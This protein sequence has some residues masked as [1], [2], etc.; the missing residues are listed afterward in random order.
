MCNFGGLV[1]VDETRTLDDLMIVRRVAREDIERQD[2]TVFGLPGDGIFAIF[3][4]AIG[5]VRAALA[6][7]SRLAALPKLGALRFR[8][9]LHVGEVLFEG[10]MPFG[11][12]IVIAARLESLADPGGIL[13]SGSVMEATASRV[14]A[15]FAENGV[16]SLKH[17][18][19][20]IATY[21][22]LPPPLGLPTSAG[23][24]DALDATAFTRPFDRRA[25]AAAWQE[26]GLESAAGMTGLR[27]PRAM[28]FVL[29]ATRSIEAAPTLQA[30]A[31]PESISPVPLLPLPMLP[32]PA[33]PL[34]MLPAPVRPISPSEAAGSPLRRPSAPPPVV[35]LAAPL[36]SRLDAAGLVDLAKLLVGHL[37]PVASI[38][39]RRHAA[40]AENPHHLVESLALIIP[41]D[42]ERAVFRRQAEI[43]IRRTQ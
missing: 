2:G 41:S 39:V 43:L 12:A 14:A 26:D 40:Q 42:G 8:I 19:R 21:K 17:S 24:D 32:A 3:E 35:P 31:W 34:P 33:S 1:S 6:I 38:L 27:L 11:E 37:G 18:P 25:A 15:T 9:G 20:R 13:V 5:A 23:E 29:P 28:P 10:T 22:V 4:S 36:A 7:Q 30:L 16:Q